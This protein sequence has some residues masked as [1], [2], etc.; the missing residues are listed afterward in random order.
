MAELEVVRDAV[1]GLLR[2]DARLTVHDG[3]PRPD[4]EPRTPPYVVA[5]VYTPRESRTKL[6]GPTDEADVIIVTHSV[7]G[8]IL[9]A[10]IVRRNVRQ[11]LL[12]VTPD[13]DGWSCGRI[14]HDEGRAT[15]W[16]QTTGTTVADAVDEWSLT[17]RPVS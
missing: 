3:P 2:A 14:A 12:D 13:A 5:Y 9:A 6:W 1:L 11:D 15:D 4:E 16:D 7:G 8:S 17:A 10:D